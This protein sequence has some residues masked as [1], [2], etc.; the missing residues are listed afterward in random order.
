VGQGSLGGRRRRRNGGGE[1]GG[2]REEGKGE[3]RRLGRE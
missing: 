2:R 1:G 3:G